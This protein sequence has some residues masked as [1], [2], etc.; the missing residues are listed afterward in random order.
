LIT[1]LRNQFRHQSIDDND[2]LA[3]IFVAA[4]AEYHSI[5]TALKLANKLDVVHLEE[6][7]HNHWRALY[8]IAATTNQCGTEPGKE[9]AF[10][11]KSS[12]N[13]NSNNTA[14]RC[15][16]CNQTGH[17][18]AHCPR[19]HNKGSSKDLT[20]GYCGKQGHEANNCFEDPNNA[21]RGPAWYKLQQS[22]EMSNVA[23]ATGGGKRKGGYINEIANAALDTNSSFE[24]IFCSL[25]FPDDPRILLDA[26]IFI[27]DS[28]ASVD[29]TGHM[30]G[31]YGMP[32]IST[33]VHGTGGK[34][35]QA[36]VVGNIQTMH[37]DNK[38]REIMPVTLHWV[39]Y[40][41][42][43]PWNLISITKR[44]KSGWKMEGDYK[45]GIIY[46]KDGVE[47]I[48]NIKKEDGRWLRKWNHTSKRRC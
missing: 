10:F 9:L 39:H 25:S 17:V 14:K 40:T 32:S 4:G 47:I 43:S 30:E 22:T 36:M 38:G 6:E 24:F 33:I 8:G 1:A 26:N 2:V 13:G 5:Y 46:Q 42:D 19:V 34:P 29:M 7:M 31:M 37:C 20:C 18:K 48:F 45:N 23:V 44:M 27:A 15:W 11:A 41:P 3:H 28:A 16:N 12:G 35:A 21:H